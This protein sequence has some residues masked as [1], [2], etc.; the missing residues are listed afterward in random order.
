MSQTVKLHYSDSDGA[1]SRWEDRADT[2]VLTYVGEEP[3]PED[4]ILQSR[5]YLDGQDRYVANQ[6]MLTNSDGKQCF[7]IPLYDLDLSNL[8]AL[9]LRSNQFPVKA[10]SYLFDIEWVYSRSGRSE[11]PLGGDVV[12]ELTE[13]NGNG[14]P[15][16]TSLE[17]RKEKDFV[18]AAKPYTQNDQHLFTPG[19]SFTLLVDTVVEREFIDSVSFKVELMFQTDS[20]DGE[21]AK[22]G[23]NKY[24]PKPDVDKDTNSVT[25]PLS[26]D[27]GVGNFCVMTSVIYGNETVLKVPYYVIIKA[28]EEETTMP[29]DGSADAGTEA[30]SDTGAD[31]GTN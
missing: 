2:L 5:A 20:E 7:F 25:I 1:A 15:V 6:W 13:T 9:T 18:P 3:L 10:V 4:L 28:S 12:A 31:T 24:L 22:T 29:D 30:G 17:F 11:S 23:W 8:Y 19:S 21:Y 27:L 26:A 16:K 14:V